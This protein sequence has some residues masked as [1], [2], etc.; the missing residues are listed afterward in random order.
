[1]NWLVLPAWYLLRAMAA[2]MSAAALGCVAA[3]LSSRVIAGDMPTWFHP[4]STLTILLAV[5]FGVGAI[6]GMVVMPPPAR[7]RTQ[8]P[9][10]AQAGTSTMAVVILLAV[11]AFAAAQVPS[12]TGWWQANHVLAAELTPG[13]PDPV[14]WDLI[15]E[16][17][18]QATPLLASLAILAT[19]LSSALALA[20]PAPVITR[21]LGACLLMTAGLVGSVFAVQHAALD[22]A[23][24]IQ[25]LVNESNDALAKAQASSWL[26]RYAASGG[27]VAARLL[28]LPA[29]LAAAWGVASVRGQSHG[30]SALGP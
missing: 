10:D 30:S 2:L 3:L 7:V 5:A 21:V 22:I 11:A 20:S 19:A 4:I 18:V 27:G 29:G 28:W 15:V 14:G 8:A 6:G 25:S 9:A 23:T 26:G 24:M 13:K 17:V 12:V 16:I 1:V